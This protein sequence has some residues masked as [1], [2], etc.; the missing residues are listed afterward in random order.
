MKYD[1]GEPALYSHSAGGNLDFVNFLLRNGVNPSNK[2]RCDWAP[3]HWAAHNGHSECVRA[4]IKAGAELSPVSDTGR[5]PLDMAIGEGHIHIIQ[6]LKEAGA[7]TYRDSKGFSTGSRHEPAEYDDSDDAH[8][9]DS[10]SRISMESLHGDGEYSDDGD[11]SVSIDDDEEVLEQ[12]TFFKSVIDSLEHKQAISGEIKKK[13][14][15][16]FFRDI[17]DVIESLDGYK[18]RLTE[19][20]S[21]KWNDIS[22]ELQQSE[23]IIRMLSFE[24]EELSQ[25]QG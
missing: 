24:E 7:H 3:L 14:L 15:Q 13:V 12:M 4:L 5:T 2:T 8:S 25:D 16:F 17:A 9:D 1:N 18:P 11:S 22:A 10:D 19:T 6:I 20:V 21:Q 23:A